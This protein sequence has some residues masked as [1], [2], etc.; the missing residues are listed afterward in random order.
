MK[1]PN[2]L[3]ITLKQNGEEKVYTTDFIPA[4]VFKAVLKINKDLQHQTDE[5]TLETICELIDLVVEAFGGQFK[6][7][8]IWNG[9]DVRVLQDELIRVFEEIAWPEQGETA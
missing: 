7:E 4:L 6:A 1:K 5:A 9:V 8:D 3:T 2:E